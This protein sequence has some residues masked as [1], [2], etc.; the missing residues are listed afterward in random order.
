MLVGN[1]NKVSFGAG[2]YKIPYEKWELVYVGE[3]GLDTCIE[4]HKYATGT[5]NDYNAVLK[6][7][8]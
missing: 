8:E 3:T 7:T 1:N 4:E 2:I 5:A 6:L